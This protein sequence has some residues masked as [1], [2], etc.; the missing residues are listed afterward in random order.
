MRNWLSTGSEYAWHRLFW[1]K[2]PPPESRKFM[3]ATFIPGSSAISRLRLFLA[4]SRTPHGLLD[5]ATP[6]L[7]A[8]LWLGGPPPWGVTVLGLI[9]VF[10]GYTAVYAL[11]DV[12]DYRQDKE[13]LAQGGLDEQIAYLDAVYMRHPMALGWLSFQEGLCWT[14][15]WALVALLG[16]YWLNPVCALIFLGGCLIETI[17]C[18]ML[19]VSHLRTLVSGV[20][21]TLGGLAA[22]LAVDP[23]PAP[24]FLLLLFLW[25][26]CWEVGGQNVPNDWHDLEEDRRLN[27]QTIPV[28]YGPGRAS[29]I[30]LVSL[31]LSVAVSVPLLK[32][33]PA[34]LSWAWVAL[35]L[36]AG[37]YFLLL[38]ALRLYRTK[39]RPQ[40]TAL[41]NQASYYPLAVLL[42]VMVNFILGF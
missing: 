8:L 30:I 14:G 42:L 22:V 27:A 41:F 23:Q 39:A 16:A 20:V 28:R 31:A 13:R 32:A 24:W 34:R 12:V 36:T 17:Y 37:F 7:G 5:L 35:G 11:N 2:S 10:A 9:T 1:E 40:A 21:K 29:V 26:F 6:A 3:N 18:L 25:L 19:G 15:A 4:L 38:P 33:A